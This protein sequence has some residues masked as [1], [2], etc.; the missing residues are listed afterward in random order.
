[1]FRE[2]VSYAVQDH[3]TLVVLDNKTKQERQA[4]QRNHDPDYCE[5]NWE[6]ELV[7]D[8]SWSH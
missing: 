6:S 3:Y 1:M 8:H 7:D 4:Y 2:W 5:D